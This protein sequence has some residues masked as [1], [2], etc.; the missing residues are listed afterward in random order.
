[1][2]ASA[3]S[4]VSCFLFSGNVSY[5][6]SDQLKVFADA[7]LHSF[8][9]AGN[10][11]EVMDGRSRPLEKS[12]S[13]MRFWRNFNI[14]SFSCVASSHQS[15][16]GLEAMQR[17]SVASFSGQWPAVLRPSWGGAAAGVTLNQP[18]IHT[19]E[20]HASPYDNSVR[21]RP[22]WEARERAGTGNSTVNI[23]VPLF[24]LWEQHFYFHIP[25]LLWSIQK[26][27]RR[28]LNLIGW[29]SQP[30]WFWWQ[31]DN[32][33]QTLSSKTCE[34]DPSVSSV[35]KFL[36]MTFPLTTGHNKFIDP[37]LV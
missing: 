12:C 2:F 23:Y 10:W 15:D 26:W 9:Q 37:R 24:I 30:F 11:L 22:L 8:I 21:W 7:S 16:R 20:T 35:E 14:I 27:I 36:L 32:T 18:L 19:S 3:A 28:S 4:F 29:K 1:M 31:T 34:T 13:L 17:L 6:K 25:F 5:F 33:V